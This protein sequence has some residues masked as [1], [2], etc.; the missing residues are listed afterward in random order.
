MMFTS[1]HFR[2]FFASILTPK[3]RNR[4]PHI[5]CSSSNSHISDAH[6]SA[7]L[8]QASL[9]P[10]RADVTDGVW[11][12]ADQRAV[13]QALE[14]ADK[15]HKQ[16]KKYGSGDVILAR[17]IEE[18]TSLTTAH[19][20]PSYRAKQ[21]RDGVLS[22]GAKNIADITTIPKAWRQQLTDQGVKTGR[23]I[24]HH[25]VRSPDGTRK[26]LL[27]L[28]DGFVVET[29]GIPSGRRSGSI[30]SINGKNNM[31]NRKMYAGGDSSEDS[32]KERLT[33]CVSSQVGCPM[34]CT[35]C[36]TGK[37]GFARNLMPHE[38]VDQVMTV[39]EMYGRRVSN[40]VFMGYDMLAIHYFC[41]IPPFLNPKP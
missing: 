13:Q 9:P 27:Q 41:R 26:F 15:I 29:V 12:Q 10:R 1:T 23:S 6:L 28:H 8:N 4:T 14:D 40:V 17:T 36:A 7:P 21:L 5:C 34:R 2:H 37:G 32:G 20:Q 16:S 30:N 33:V 19:G 38:I 3:Y 24:L 35:F 31:S 18:V 22:Q 25:E 39:G 11:D